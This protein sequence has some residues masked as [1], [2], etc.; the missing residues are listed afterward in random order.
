MR[1]KNVWQA[2]M[3]R[4]RLAVSSIIG[5]ILVFAMVLT[6]VYGYFYMATQDEQNLL[7]LGLQDNLNMQT[8]AEESLSV[9]GTLIGPSLG[10]A[11]NN[12]G[13]A[14]TIASYQVVDRATN[15]IV[16]YSSGSG[17]T[18]PLPV[19]LAQGQSVVLNTGF[20]YPPGK[21]YAIT[22]LTARG[23]V[24][25]GTYPPRILPPNSIG[26]LISEGL[27]SLSMNFSSF[28]YYSYSQTSPSYVLNINHPHQGALV[29]YNV[30]I[31]FS[32][33]ITNNDPYHSSITV[34]PHTEVVLDEQCTDGCG[35][36]PKMD[37]FVMNVAANGA[38]TSVNQGSFV[39]IV[40]PYG[41][42]QKLYFGSYYDLSLNSYSDTKIGGKANPG[43]P[44]AV[45]LVV[46]GTTEQVQNAT[47]Y[48]Q[49][50]PFADSYPAD[51]LAWY[52]E[53]PTSCAAGLS[54]TSNL[55]V[56]NSQFSSTSINEIV[57]NASQ[58]KPVT[59]SAP[60]GWIRHTYSN[61]TIIWTPNGNGHKISP[62]NYNMFSWTGT[63]PSTVGLQ[64]IIPFTIYWDSGSKVVVTVQQSAVGCYVT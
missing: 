4:R 40:I 3:K 56:N 63:A 6:I 26:S 38:V 2:R 8:K 43:V 36:F 62:G 19:G 34:D 33:S 39:P 37:F 60:S 54:V 35:T 28:D 18:P 25:V 16:A 1:G 32:L 53:S 5:T 50:L 59:A 57:L 7:R 29:P 42:T 15:N 52:S 27:G 20:V 22:V 45:F 12:T 21:S 11:I 49:N 10:I 48:S 9:A 46:S 30:P 61:G 17:S 51:N 24:A 58:F 31:V 14:L 13:I 55:M 47:L 44:L 64:T 23:T 41:A